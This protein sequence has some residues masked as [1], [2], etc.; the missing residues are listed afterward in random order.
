MVASWKVKPLYEHQHV[1]RDGA[2]HSL[3]VIYLP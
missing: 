3:E 2:R 1:R